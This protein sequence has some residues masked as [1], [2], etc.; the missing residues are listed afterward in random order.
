MNEMRIAPSLVCREH[1]ELNMVFPH[2]FAGELVYSV[3]SRFHIRSGNQ[4]R[5]TTS[6]ALFGYSTAFRN[7][8]VP[9]GLNWLSVI[10]RGILNPSEETLRSRTLLKAYLPLIPVNRRSGI[11]SAI[12]A[13]DPTAAKARSGLSRYCEAAKLL[14]FCDQ[15]VIDQT[16]MEGVSFWKT[17]HQLPG[18]WLCMEHKMVLRL[19]DLQNTLTR[20]WK[21]PHHFSESAIQ[22]KLSSMQMLKLFRVMD[23]MNW[24]A[25]KSFLDTTNLLIMLRLR[26]RLA[27]MCRSELKLFTVEVEHLQHLMTN[28]YS[29]VTTPDVVAA[30]REDWFSNLFNEKRHYNPLTWA[31]AL[32]FCGDTKATFLDGEYVDASNRRP[33]P[34]L[35]GYLNAAQN[36]RACAPAQLYAALDGALHKADAVRNSEFT[37]SEI[38]NWLIKDPELHRHWKKS[39]HDRKRRDSMKTIKDYLRCNS[40]S[41]RVDV[42][43]ACNKEYRWLEKNDP[44][45]FAS[46]VPPIS[47]KYDRQLN[48]AF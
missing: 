5:E 2:P 9:A 29:D 24:I 46:T 35:F 8:Q 41:L 34:D 30:M 40:E 32:A 25:K 31:L 39:C 17:D 43:N 26:L 44:E 11:F 21:L 28:F 45:G 1:T 33:Q 37:E 22:P 42:L 19:V 16:K 12:A 23:V 10:S 4:R 48:L 7:P 18:V 36:K 20:D 47:R 27:G 3:C 6:I 13:S 38:N 15:C 14:K